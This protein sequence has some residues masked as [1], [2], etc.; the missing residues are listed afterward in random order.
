MHGLEM[1]ARLLCGIMVAPPS[2]AL[3]RVTTRTGTVDNA[4]AG[5]YQCHLPA[6]G[7]VARVAVPP[8]NR[9]A[10]PGTSL[11]LR[12]K[13]RLAAADIIL[14]PYCCMEDVRRALS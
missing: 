5:T 11:R 6:L 14:R 3:V 1:L 8:R 2:P 13:A 7:A 9:A 4:N 12:R 10:T